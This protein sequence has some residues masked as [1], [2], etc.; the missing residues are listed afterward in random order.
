MMKMSQQI[1]YQH[2]RVVRPVEI[3][4]VLLSSPATRERERL[5]QV[6]E[7]DVDQAED[8]RQPG[9]FN[10]L[11]MTRRGGGVILPTASQHAYFQ[12]FFCKFPLKISDISLRF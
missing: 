11:F 2:C 5:V 8:Q 4:D 3:R 10:N 7:G 1:A 9:L 6:R 12:Q